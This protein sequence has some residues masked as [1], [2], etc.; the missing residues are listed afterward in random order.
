MTER[1]TM[2]AL[3]NLVNLLTHYADGNLTRSELVSELS[4]DREVIKLL[5]LP[6]S[7]FPPRE[8]L[9]SDAEALHLA[10]ARGETITIS[11]HCGP[12]TKD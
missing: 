5:P 8:S 12:P 2:R 11:S 4:K 7:C 10:H 9:R 1:E 3:H 6:A